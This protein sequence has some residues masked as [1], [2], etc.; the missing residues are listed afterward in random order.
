MWRAW[1]I[2]GFALTAC[3]E[4]PEVDAAL[5]KGDPS[6]D[7]PALLP[8]EQLLSQQEA[9]LHETDDDTLRARADGLRSRADALRGP[10]IDPRTRDRMEDGVTQP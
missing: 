4:F 2:L 5:A 6:V 10:V 7:Y 9:R 8:F 1:I 3:A